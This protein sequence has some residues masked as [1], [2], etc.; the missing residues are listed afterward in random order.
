MGEI[1]LAFIYKKMA[2]AVLC[3]MGFPEGTGNWETSVGAIGIVQ[4]KDDDGL[5]LDGGADGGGF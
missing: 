4:V 1:R 5:G 3:S 2:L